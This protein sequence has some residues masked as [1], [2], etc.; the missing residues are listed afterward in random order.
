MYSTG[1]IAGTTQT[2]RR[3]L[4]TETSLIA[5][6][7]VCG[8]LRSKKTHSQDPDRW[9]TRRAYE[10]TYGVS[11]VG[12]LFTHTYCSGCHADFMQRAKPE[13]HSPMPATPYGG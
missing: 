3:G 6:C 9:V 8:L 12:S 2:K 7:C 11:L 5:T 10:Q 1:M 4:R 13:K